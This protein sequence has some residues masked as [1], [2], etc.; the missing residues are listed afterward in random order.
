[1]ET[2]STNKG[3]RLPWCIRRLIQFRNRLRRDLIG[4]I[5]Q[6]DRKAIRREINSLQNV[7]KM[8]IQRHVD[9]V[10]NKRLAKVDNPCH[11]I[12][13]LVKTLKTKSMIT[14][15]LIKT[16]G[17]LTSNTIEQCEV[18]AD[19][20]KSNMLLTYDW[21]DAE[22]ASRVQASIDALDGQCASEKS[23]S[24]FLIRPHELWCLILRLKRRKAPGED[25]IHN[26]LL[27]NLSQKVIV[28]LAKIMN[29]CFRLNFF[30]KAWKTTK[31]IAIKKP[32][33]NERIPV[34]YRPISLL[35][36]LAKLFEAAIYTRLLKVD[37]MKKGLL[38]TTSI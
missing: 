38:A 6:N 2:R 28:Y 18:L 15:P 34:S 5:D 12:W 9:T 21:H 33:K 23:K 1:M 29:G 16:D 11:D 17:S 31:V 35:P 4:T 27:K 37:K 7:I 14:P 30:P 10:W 24:S 36:V 3:V 32:N 20:F 26:A 25:N 8:K 19:A 22:L 13:R